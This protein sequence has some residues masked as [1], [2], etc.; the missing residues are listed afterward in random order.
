MSFIL[1]TNT[2]FPFIKV[3]WKHCICQPQWRRRV[4]F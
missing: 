2:A 4:E 1:T 3:E